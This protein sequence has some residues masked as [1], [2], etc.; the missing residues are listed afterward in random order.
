M[1]KR[2][3]ALLKLAPVVAKLDPVLLLVKDIPAR[4]S[5]PSDPSDP[6]ERCGAGGL[7]SESMLAPAS[8]E[9]DCAGDTNALP[10]VPGVEN[11]SEGVPTGDG[12]PRAPVLVAVMMPTPTLR[13]QATGASP[14]AR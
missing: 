7:S 14:L 10:V 1:S 9:N 2:E 12:H 6:S 8:S 3:I 11:P 13:A 5:D 4:P